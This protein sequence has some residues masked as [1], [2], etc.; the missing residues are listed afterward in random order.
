MAR[1]VPMVSLLVL[2]SAAGCSPYLDDFRYAPR[3]AVAEIRSTSPQQAPA[4]TAM[5]S[6]IGVRR[7]DRNEGIPESVEVRLRLENN[8][9][10]T[11]VFD[12]QTLNLT[13]GQ[14]LP[15]P[16]PVVRAPSP[17]TLTPMQSMTLTAFFPLPRS[18]HEGDLDSLV[19]RWIVQV[20][21]QKVSQSVT[22]RQVYARV[23]Y[24]DPY[25]GPYRGYPPYFWYGGV[26]FIHRR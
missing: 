19:L 11:V 6:V 8:G 26:V 9:A 7:E 18:F 12:V 14:L 5:A 3:P 22:F 10:E 13:G 16:P 1:L 21:G 20:G 23:Y 4:V 17:I 25:W 24:Y 15:F 2:V